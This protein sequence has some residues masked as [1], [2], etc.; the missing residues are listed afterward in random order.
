MKK[1]LTLLVLF[2][3]GC[4]PIDEHEGRILKQSNI[5][6]IELT[7]NTTGFIVPL[8][9]YPTDDYSEYERIISMKMSYPDVPIIVIINPHNGPGEFD[10]E[11]VKLVN[12]L[13]EAGVTMI[14][15]V[16]AIYSDRSLID[17]EADIETY[18]ELYP[19]IVGYFVDEVDTGGSLDY[20]S[21]IQK[22]SSEKDFLIGNPGTRV[23]G[24]YFDVFDIL[25][26]AEM[27]YDDITEKFLTSFDYDEIP[28][29]QKSVISY[30][31][32]DE[33]EAFWISDYVGWIYITEYDVYQKLSNQFEEQVE[34]VDEKNRG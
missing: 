23:T 19:N 13:N 10:E 18:E 9:L 2:L 24:E 29:I 27:M 4:T 8:Y 22:L 5:L 31:T 16:H 14:G 28:N 21:S 30:N 6:N 26:I 17:I 20:Y 11:Y 25:V 12:D 7:E 15:Y 33:L 1:I 32:P 34:L 3:F